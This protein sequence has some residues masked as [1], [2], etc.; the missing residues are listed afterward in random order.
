MM[1]A[2]K[3]KAKAAVRAGRE[4]RARRAPRAALQYTLEAAKFRIN[5]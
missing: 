2:W 1:T 3:A 5:F 4:C